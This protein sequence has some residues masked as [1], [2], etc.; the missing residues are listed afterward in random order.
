MNM[1]RHKITHATKT[2]TRRAEWKPST[3][4]RLTRSVEVGESVGLFSNWHS[5]SQ[6]AWV[7]V[8]AMY[9]ERVEDMTA[10]DCEEEGRPDLTPAEFYDWYVITF[11]FCCWVLGGCGCS[12]CE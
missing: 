12:A 10:N 11:V 3:V 2:A 8:T 4:R 7:K 6:F 5:D 1:W 9:Y